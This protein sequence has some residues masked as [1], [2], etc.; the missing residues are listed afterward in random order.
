MPMM[1]WLLTHPL[2][3]PPGWMWWAVVGIL[4]IGVVALV[5]IAIKYR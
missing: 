1:T 4:A 5:V 3:N 2:E